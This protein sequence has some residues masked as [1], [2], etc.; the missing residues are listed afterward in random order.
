MN[1]IV[2]AY[3]GGLDTA[4]ILKILT[5]RGHEVIAY[6][7]DIGQREDLEDLERRALATGAVKAMAVSPAPVTS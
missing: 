4:C 6:A 3:S 2:L 1:K 5:R 7:A